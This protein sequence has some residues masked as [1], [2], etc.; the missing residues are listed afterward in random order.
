[1]PFQAHGH[2]LANKPIGFNQ[3]QAMRSHVFAPSETAQM[4]VID[5]YNGAPTDISI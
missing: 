5:T 4:A 3:L 1:M 2:I